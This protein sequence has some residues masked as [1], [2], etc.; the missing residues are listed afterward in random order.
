M[1]RR[2]PRGGADPAQPAPAT[3]ERA[4]RARDGGRLRARLRRQERHHQPGHG[5]GRGKRSGPMD[6]ALP[7]RPARPHRGDPATA[8]GQGRPGPRHRGLAA[9]TS[10]RGRRRR[11]RSRCSPSRP[12]FRPTSSA[13]SELARGVA[14]RELTAWRSSVPSVVSLD[15]RLPAA[16]DQ[17]LADLAALRIVD[18]AHPDRAVVAAG[19]PWFMTLFG[20]DSLLT[21]WMTLPFDGSLAGG[22]L[23]SLA[24]LQGTRG[25]PGVR[26]AA[27]SHPARTA[28]PR[29]AARSPPA[30]AITARWTPRRSSSA[31]PPKPGGGGRSTRTPS[32]A[33]PRPSVAPSTG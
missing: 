30:A 23:A 31:S 24:D 12:A 22:V 8:A 28:A 10:P 19:A 33:W 20:R 29:A 17:A 2:Q 1:A 16:V 14:I 21:A 11:S 4:P 7:S 25:R 26:G 27:G 32:A 3:R 5:P 9:A 18:R 6:P 13:P 15:P